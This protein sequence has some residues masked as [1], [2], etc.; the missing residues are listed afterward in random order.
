[1]IKY[2]LLMLPFMLPLLIPEAAMIISLLV[3]PLVYLV[4]AIAAIFHSSSQSLPW[5]VD[6]QGGAL[7]AAVLFLIFIGGVL[8]GGVGLLTMAVTWIPV[9]MLPSFM[10]LVGVAVHHE[11]SWRGY[12]RTQ[13][14]ERCDKQANIY[15]DPDI[16]NY[17]PVTGKKLPSFRENNTEDKILSVTPYQANYR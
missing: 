13:Y 17:T 1:M 6:G 8:R 15:K 16:C 3:W 2:I 5:Y 7:L 4:I 12:K 14:V 10:M 9:F 11:N